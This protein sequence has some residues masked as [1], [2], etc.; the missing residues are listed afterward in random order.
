MPRP[1][2]R[3]STRRWPRR[4]TGTVAAGALWNAKGDQAVFVTAVVGQHVAQH[5]H[6]D[7]ARFQAGG[8]G[9][10]LM[11]ANVV[12]EFCVLETE[13]SEILPRVEPWT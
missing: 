7:A 3:P 1:Y 11:Q 9:P 6:I 4:P 5:H 12:D 13:F 10:G 2:P 8:C